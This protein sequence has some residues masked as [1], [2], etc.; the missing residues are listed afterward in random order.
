MK[1]ATKNMDRLKGFKTLTKL[2]TWLDTGALDMF[3]MCRIVDMGGLANMKRVMLANAKTER[4]D[5]HTCSS[6]KEG[7][8]SGTTTWENYMTLLDRGDKRIM[9]KIKVETK[10]QIAELSKKYEEVIHNYK[11]DV[12]GQ[13]FDVGLV[14]TGVPEV[15]LEPEFEEEE[16]VKVDIIINGGFHSR[17]KEN[18]IIKASARI[19]GM[20]KVIEDH[21]VQVNLKMVST[22]SYYDNKNSSETLVGV[23]H[24]KD[25]DEP[26]NYSKV[27]S[28]MTPS[29]HR[30]TMLK[31]IEMQADSVAGGYGS[32]RAPES[33]ISL[34]DDRQID[35]LEQM[36]FK[37]K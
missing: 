25:Y 32:P 21:G 19:I 34:H 8:W 5:K 3:K 33:F 31:M 17:I 37:G 16:T 18:E 1:L 6:M 15:W 13:F 7:K 30:R 4:R 12:T 36:L 9:N 26:I 20:I 29:F 11:F 35:K 24:V 27:S 14:L 28:L 10:L 2:P 23:V 22:N